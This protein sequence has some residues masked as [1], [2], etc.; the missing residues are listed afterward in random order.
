M[1]IMVY[2]KVQGTKH[3][4]NVYDDLQTLK[5]EV[6]SE[7]VAHSKTEWICSIFFSINGEEFKLFT[8]DEK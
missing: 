4:I 8:G 6:H 1:E 7:L 2:A 5:S 3:F